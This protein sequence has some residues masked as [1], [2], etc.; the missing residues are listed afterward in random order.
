VSQPHPRLKKLILGRDNFRE[1]ESQPQ[2]SLRPNHRCFFLP[3]ES[4][5]QSLEETGVESQPHE[6]LRPKKLK[7][8][9]RFLQ[10]SSQQSLY[11]VET[12]VEHVSH[13]PQLFLW[14]KP[15]KN[16]FFPELQVSHELQSPADARAP[17]RPHVRNAAVAIESNCF[18]NRS[19]L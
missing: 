5:Q 2:S 6:S 19:L 10:G 18:M 13:P 16:D 12:G 17:T 9:F 8:C 7:P 11:E 15:P 14:K 1:P 4:S 3:Q